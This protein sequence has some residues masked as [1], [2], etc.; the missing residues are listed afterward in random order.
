MKTI[1]NNLNCGDA[2]VKDDDLILYILRRTWIILRNETSTPPEVQFALQYQEMRI[3]S[4]NSTTNTEN[5]STP[6]ANSTYRGGRGQNRGHGNRGRNH[7]GRGGRNN[8]NNH[9][10]CQLYGRTSHNRRLML[11]SIQCAFRWFNTTV[12]RLVTTG[13]SKSSMVLKLTLP[14]PMMNKLVKNGI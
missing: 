1:A 10:M 2:L 9:P 13:T 3:K 12:T 8:S 11:P 6:S 5:Y 4:L 14:R 7:G